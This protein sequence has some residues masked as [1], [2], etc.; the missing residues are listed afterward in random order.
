MKKLILFLY[1]VL[2]SNVIAFEINQEFL[3]QFDGIAIKTIRKAETYEANNTNSKSEFNG[4]RD[5]K[6]I[7]G[8][9]KRIFSTRAVYLTDLEFIEDNINTTWYYYK[10]SPTNS[11]RQYSLYYQK[12]PILRE[13][14]REGDLMLLGKIDDNNL[15]I[16]IIKKD[17]KKIR[18]LLS[19]L[20]MNDFENIEYKNKTEKSENKPFIEDTMSSHTDTS[21]LQEHEDIKIFKNTKTNR[22]VVLGKASKIKDGDTIIVSDMFNVRMLGIDAPESKQICKDNKDQQY[23]CG[24][25]AEQYLQQLIGKANLTCVNNGNE[26]YG[27]FLFVCKNSKKGDINR[28][29]VRNGWAVAYYSDL[30]KED[31]KYAKQNKLGIW[32]G[33][34]QIPSEWRKQNKGR[35]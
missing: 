11:D 34:F 2:V 28:E 27:R 26:K 5:F 25:K 14:M 24:E 10:K 31:E 35:R 16:L 12:K 20:N 15:V 7:L 33:T 22:I 3:N 4:I 23:K 19:L 6:E 17:S 8:E 32:S 18:E 29:M 30:Y 9:E 21:N 1:F 13:N